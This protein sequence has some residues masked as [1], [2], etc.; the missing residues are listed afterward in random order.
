MHYL[1]IPFRKPSSASDFSCPDGE[2]NP[3]Y[4]QLTTNNPQLTPDI[5]FALVRTRLP[6]WNLNPDQYPMKTLVASE[7]SMEYWTS[8]GSQLLS[9]FKSEAS[10]QN[11]FVAP[12]Y[13]YAA[14]KTYDGIYLSPSDRIL[15]T[16]NSTVPLLA[17]DGNISA[18]E[19][20][21]KIAA[22][23]CELYFRMRAPEILRDWVGI[24]ES[25]QIFVSD[26]IQNWNTFQAFIPYKHITTDNYCESLDLDSGEIAQRRVCS[27]TLALAWRANLTQSGK[28]GTSKVSDIKFYP[29]ASI[30]LGEVDIKSSWSSLSSVKESQTVPN[31]TE[32]V[33]DGQELIIQGRGR[34]ISISTRPLKLTSAARF[35]RLIR[36]YLRG[37]F[38]PSKITFSIYASH[39]MLSWRC[40]SKRTGGEVLAFPQTSFRFFKAQVAGKLETGENLQ[41]ISFTYVVY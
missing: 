19:L 34:E 24:I 23:V 6:G 7:P 36:A 22:A 27:E 1:D 14:W 38:K 16:P 12:F 28:N 39:D 13:A 29:F 20:E 15:L 11:F 31:N 25:L 9:Q 8:L 5:D 33:K 30:P 2:I 10:N 32:T 17:T 18:I 26:P 21:F 35:K 41:G 3:H 4:L 40:I 37:N